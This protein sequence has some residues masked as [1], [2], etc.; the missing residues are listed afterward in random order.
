MS[1]AI[2]IGLKHLDSAKTRLGPDLSGEQRRR[3]MRRMLEVVT[4]A[5]LK[6][7]VGPV[8]LA[9]SEPDGQ[10]IAADLGVGLADDGGLPW[11][12]GLV[13]AL[14]A[15]ERPPRRV[16]YL[17][18]DLPTV[19]ADEIARWWPRRPTPVSRS[20]AR[21]T[22]VPTPCWSRLPQPLRP[23]SVWPAAPSSTA[24]APPRRA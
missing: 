15:L 14:E 23:R 18:G 8:F 21:T 17:A 19:S 20:P 3:L 12:E 10:A 5:A 1:V 9:T 6:A 22:A 4:A 11:N 2:L 13:H 16:L 7:D 24:A